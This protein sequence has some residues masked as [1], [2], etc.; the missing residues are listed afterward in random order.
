ME[1]YYKAYDELEAFDRE[2]E[3]RRIIEQAEREGSSESYKL[4][5]EEEAERYDLLTALRDAMT[6]VPEWPGRGYPLGLPVPM[7]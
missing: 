4:K 2:V 5:P 7:G 3:K 1:A 6:K